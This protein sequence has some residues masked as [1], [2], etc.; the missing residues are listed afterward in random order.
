LTADRFVPDP[1]APVPGGRLYRTGDLGRYRP[2][3]VL[4][5]LGRVDQQIKLRGFRIEL[6]EIEEALRGHAAVS[7]AAVVER[8]RGAGDQQLV[9]YVVY[10]DEGEPTATQLRRYLKQKLPPYMIPSAFV[11]LD[12]LPLTPNGKLDRRALARIVRGGSSSQREIQ[13]PRTPGEEIVARV[14][15]EALGVEAVGVQDNFFDIGGH[16]LL[17]MRVIARLESQLGVRIHPREMVFQT[18]EQLAAM[19]AE[20]APALSGEAGR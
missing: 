4:E 2:D 5:F 6:G 19:C 11:G 14:W 8:R 1:H 13:A 9:A 17:S 12:A 10:A 7:A 3:G 18:L 16:S 20:R 15:R